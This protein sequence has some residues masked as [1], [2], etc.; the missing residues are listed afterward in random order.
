MC[1]HTKM[2][3]FASLVLSSLYCS[4]FL[5]SY[6]M[7]TRFVVN[8]VFFFFSFYRSDKKRWETKTNNEKPCLSSAIRSEETKIVSSYDLN[9]ANGTIK[10]YAGCTSTRSESRIANIISNALNGSLRNFVRAVCFKV[11]NATFFFFTFFPRKLEFVAF[12][13]HL[14][15]SLFRKTRETDFDTYLYVHYHSKVYGYLLFSRTLWYLYNLL[16][17]H[18]SNSFTKTYV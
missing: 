4:R 11:H 17:V 12:Y 18:A 3:A 13:L 14:F 15:R 1:I 5:Y 8:S 6:S 7:Q 9:Y 10:V 2:W 16:F